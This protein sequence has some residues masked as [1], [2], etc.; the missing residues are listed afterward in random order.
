MADVI[1]IDGA[2]VIARAAIDADEFV[3]IS[4][5]RALVDGMA[6]R[7]V[8]EAENE[9]RLGQQIQS[10]GDAGGLDSAMVQRP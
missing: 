2:Q 5:Q 9:T 7:T 1:R 8:R 4:D 10:S 3:C 6:V